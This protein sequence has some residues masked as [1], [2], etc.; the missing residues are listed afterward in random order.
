MFFKGLVAIALIVGLTGCGL[1]IGEKPA[2]EDPVGFSGNGLGCI[3]NIPQKLRSY[4]NDEMSVEQI[5]V[6]VR[7][8]QNSFTTFARYTRGTDRSTYT[9]GEL[10]SFFEGYFLG[11][12]KISDSLLFE[13]MVIKQF[14]V[15]GTVTGV[16][17]AE[18]VGAIR[19]LDDIRVEMIR[20]KPHLRMLNPDL[21]VKQD[22]NGFGPRLAEAYEAM[23]T[24]TLTLARRLA[25]S[26]NSYRLSHYSVFTRE[27]R[28]FLR[29][30]EAFQDTHSAEEWTELLRACKV[31]VVGGDKPDEI[32]PSE[33][34]PLFQSLT[35]GYLT[36]LQFQIGV[37]GQVVTRGV[38]LQNL[39]YLGEQILLFVEESVHRHP[40]KTL[41]FAAIER[42]VATTSAMGWLP[43]GWRAESVQ[44]AVRVLINRVFG[45][46]S[47]VPSERHAQGL[48]LQALANIKA[49][50]YR[51]SY[52][53]T[54]L[55]QEF[56][57]APSANSVEVPNLQSLQIVSLGVRRRLQGLRGSEWDNFIKVREL[58]RPLYSTTGD[59]RVWIAATT[60]LSR[61][62]VR[63]G[64]DNL[65]A[66]NLLRSA[67]GLVFRG[68]AEGSGS[69]F[70]WTASIKES[71]LKKVFEELREIAIDVGL[72]DQRTFNTGNRMFIE[73]NLFTFGSDG[74]RTGTGFA[75]ELSFSEAL[76]LFALTYSGGQMAKGIYV[77]LEKNC[78]RSGPAD[79]RGTLNFARTCVEAHLGQVIVEEMYHLPNLQRFLM[80]KTAAE[81]RAY[82]GVLLE[83]AFS[84]LRSTREWVE[85]SELA[86]LAVITQYSEMAVARFDSNMDGILVNS[87]L[88]PAIVHFTGYIQKM[89]AEKLDIR[90]MSEARAR[91][92]LAFILAHKYIPDADSW[93]DS[94]TVWKYEKFGAPNLSLDRIAMA[95]VFRAIGQKLATA[96]MAPSGVGQ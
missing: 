16:T 94:G 13:F 12:R 75:S 77:G 88:E 2:S 93:S 65:S 19:F 35:R 90:N 68:Y 57:F 92:V 61:Y 95:E 55:E 84:T 71:E 86:T 21:A 67:I 91:A 28:K 80:G 14:L 79:I 72:V 11:K 29:W 43:K 41:G 25:S 83:T 78:P 17:R 51:W 50:F 47:V 42:L 36:F 31:V 70:L 15:G 33:F 49:E 26:G 46:S 44:Q 18:L 82:A 22:V 85:N 5:N 38:G 96:G 45:D 58:V 89:A 64:F 66:M 37:N 40:S 7:C 1:K 4:V 20:I 53:Q 27:I 24:T 62:D 81:R 52:V 34:Q 76:E 56:Y 10:R 9:P 73:G 23:R 69:Q 6:F 48:T 63:S 32:E 59:R 87:E 3:G 30:E 60:E 39:I 74:V 54:S 8:L